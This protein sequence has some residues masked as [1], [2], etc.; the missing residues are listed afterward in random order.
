M[1]A[2]ADTCFFVDLYYRREPALIWARSNPSTVLYASLITVGEL[3]VGQPSRQK[4]EERLQGVTLLSIDEEVAW[5]FGQCGRQ[6]RS[7]GNMIGIGDLW[8]AA[9]ALT[10]DLPVLTRNLSEFQRVPRLQVLPY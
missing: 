9:T 5:I 4:I 8:I 7:Q 2:L 1:V 10:A 6:L 3:G